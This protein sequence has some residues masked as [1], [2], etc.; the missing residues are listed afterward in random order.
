MTL[1]QQ[2]LMNGIIRETGYGK[3]HCICGSVFNS[4]TKTHLTSLKHLLYLKELTRTHTLSSV[5]N[6]KRLSSQILENG[7]NPM[8]EN[9]IFKDVNYLQPNNCG[10]L[11]EL[12]IISLCIQNNIPFSIDKSKGGTYDICIYDKTCEVKTARL[13]TTNSLQHETLRDRKSDFF[14]FVSLLPGS[15]YITI[16]PTWDMSM[17]NTVFSLTPHLRKNADEIYKF[18]FTERH[19][20]QYAMEQGNSIKLYENAKMDVNDEKKYISSFLKYHFQTLK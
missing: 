11:G 19:I 15:Y 1:K 10:M 18:A 5:D 8:W 13:G 16:I 4:I 3:F 17:M 20:Q 6:L 14:I 12:L 2:C 9:N 7:R